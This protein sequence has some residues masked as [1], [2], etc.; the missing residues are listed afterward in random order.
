MT[1]KV[2]L[3]SPYSLRYNG[4]G[5]RWAIE[6][7]RRFKHVRFSV[8]T[9]TYAGENESIEPDPAFLE[10]CQR[11]KPTEVRSKRIP[12]GI[13]VP[14][15]RLFGTLTRKAAESD[16]ILFN[17]VFPFHESMILS[18]KRKTG[19]PA[20]SMYQAPIVNPTVLTAIYRGVF[21]TR[22]GRSFDAHHVLNHADYDELIR[23]RYKRVY[24]IPNG[25]DTAYFCPESPEKRSEAFSIL[26]V[27]RLNHHKGFDILL[28]VARPLFKAEKDIEIWVAGS[29][30]WSRL[31]L[32][33]CDSHPRFRTFGQCSRSTL[34]RLYS[35]ASI[36]VFPSRWEGLPLAGIEA[37]SSGL[38]VVASRI[39]GFQGIC[40]DGVNGITVETSQSVRG[41]LRAIMRLYLIWKEEPE[42]FRRFQ[43]AS[44]NI[45]VNHYDWSIIAPQI[46]SELLRVCDPTA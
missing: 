11:L 41:F 13:L 33:L 30:H 17:N 36:A 34:K 1:N 40:M 16:C 18:V 28:D 10:D 38:P 43:E 42:T 24:K 20:V 6:V 8:V 29:G 44:R 21:S 9:T 3:Y 4:G 23:R 39:P 12:P 2:L 7:A 14:N 19:C 31:A 32:S 25:V 37:L 45:A 27:G 15:P 35:H 22:I 5:E 26:F 46:E